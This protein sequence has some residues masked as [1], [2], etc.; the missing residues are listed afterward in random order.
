MTQDEKVCECGHTAKAHDDAVG[1]CCV[2]YYGG[3][4][5]GCLWFTPTKATTDIR[6]QPDATPGLL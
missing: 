1:T 2:M 6:G 5:C 4:L 3:Y